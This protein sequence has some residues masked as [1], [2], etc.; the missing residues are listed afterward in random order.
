[1]RTITCQSFVSL[2]G[3]INHMERWHFAYTDAES[4]ALALDQL[5]ASD[6]LLMGR[7]T[8]EV[9]AGVWPGR[10]GDYPE[11]INRLPKYVVSSTL[12]D[13]AWANTTVLDEDPVAAIRALKR[14]EGRQILMHGYGPLAKTLLDE[15]VLDELQL[16]VHPVL[17]GVGTGQDLLL[18]PGLNRTL[19]L[20]DTSALDNGIV[21]LT[22][23]NPAAAQDGTT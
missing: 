5:R 13:P 21:I 8:Y 18:H 16:W 15:G 7:R 4:D 20:A 11:L 10:D 6:A 22:Y 2:D 12:T 19:Q 14:Q 23:R 17:A 3:V 1:M 9:Y